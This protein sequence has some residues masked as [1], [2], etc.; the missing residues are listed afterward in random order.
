VHHLCLAPKSVLNP[1]VPHR[2]NQQKCRTAC[3]QPPL[4]S[5][6]RSRQAESV[7]VLHSS[8]EL[9]L[10]SS[11]LVGR[12]TQ[13]GKSLGRA[14]PKSSL[15]WFI[16][17]GRFSVNIQPHPVPDNCLQART[18]SNGLG[19]HL[20]LESGTLYSWGGRPERQQVMGIV[21]AQS[22]QVGLLIADHT[23]FAQTL[24]AYLE[25]TFRVVGVVADGRALLDHA[26]RSESCGCST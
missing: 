24:R 6:K 22:S 11:I 19:Q 16:Q 15:D 14:N 3:Q 20:G 2:V 26:S 9:Y 7:H 5:I 17:P 25:K 18:L 21:P 13:L 12:F 23:I 1:V 8:W 10:L 4:E